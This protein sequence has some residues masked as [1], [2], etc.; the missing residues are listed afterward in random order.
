MPVPVNVHLSADR[1]L[2]G[3]LIGLAV[4]CLV[5][6]AVAQHLPRWCKT[7]VD[8]VG[9]I[10]LWATCSKVPGQDGTCT[11]IGSEAFTH[12]NQGKLSA[13]AS[14]LFSAAQGMTIASFIFTFVVLIALL[15]RVHVGVV[16]F[17]FVVQIVLITGA[18]G[19][20]AGACDNVANV[21]NP[22]IDASM[23]CAAALGSSVAV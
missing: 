15:V 10:G 12:V 5:L 7:N 13:G 1:V 11:R 8:E 21:K 20:M 6:L 4:V 16:V 3:T 9:T 18:I 2:T 23:A 19:T 17:M 22:H 14:A